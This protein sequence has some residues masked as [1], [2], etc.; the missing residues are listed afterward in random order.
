MSLRELLAPLAPPSAPAASVYRLAWNSRVSLGAVAL[1]ALAV[2]LADLALQ[3]LR[4][5]TFD[6][7]TVAVM[8]NG[9]G[10]GAFTA[11][12]VR[13]G[14]TAATDLTLTATEITYRTPFSTL[15][16]SWADAVTVRP[17]AFAP[18][19]ERLLVR[20]V[21]R[22][23]AIPLSAFARN[24]RTSPLAGDLHRYAPWLSK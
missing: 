3:L 13:A 24:W 7:F 8:L 10:M 2:A 20:D 14:L 21:G 5:R 23:R 12:L 16:V 11:A 17:A 1:T 19:G 4:F 15:A 9:I 6:A 18:L 22:V